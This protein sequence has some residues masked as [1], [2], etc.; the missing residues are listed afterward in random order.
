MQHLTVWITLLQKFM[1]AADIDDEL[2]RLNNNLPNTYQQVVITQ[3][4]IDKADD[5]DDT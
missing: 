4:E 2:T 1:V 5:E 3:L